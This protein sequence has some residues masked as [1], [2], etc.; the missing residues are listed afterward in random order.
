MKTIDFYIHHFKSLISNNLVSEKA[1]TLEE[2]YTSLTNQI[3]IQL[4]NIEKKDQ[5]MK[6][7]DQAYKWIRQDVLG[8]QTKVI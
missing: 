3:K 1:I 7:L 5:S 2:V 8:R 6:N 4:I